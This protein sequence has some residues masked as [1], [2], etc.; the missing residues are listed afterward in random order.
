[1]RKLDFGCGN[2]GF[3]GQD[4]IHPHDRGSWLLKNGDE[5]TVALDIDPGAITAART[6][7]KN[8]TQFVISDGRY[9]PFNDDSFDYIREWGT[10]HH[11]HDYEFAVKEIA[12]VLKS[13]GTFAACETID[14]D[15]F[16]S[17]CRTLVGS[18][19]GN[20]IQSRFDSKNLITS[21]E[22]Y[23]E[24]QQVEYWYRPLLIDLPSYFFEHYPG[25]VY[26]VYFQ[27]YGSKLRRK[28]RLLPRFARHVT[29]LATK[30]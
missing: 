28:L 10:L 17:M 11:I 9:L 14:N 29:I 25:W 23:F 22:K 6:R 13:S 4:A 3:P 20:R 18:W 15:P 21:F 8:H 24:I 7:I 16:Y 5:D 19:K 26:G 27:Y 1:M 30:K 12:R 2:G